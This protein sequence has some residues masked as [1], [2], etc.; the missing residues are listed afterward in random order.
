MAV[1]LGLN[2]DQLFRFTTPIMA[3][4]QL[5]RRPGEIRSVIVDTFQWNG[6]TVAQSMDRF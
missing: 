6:S 3:R 1:K 2:H 4:F 5:R